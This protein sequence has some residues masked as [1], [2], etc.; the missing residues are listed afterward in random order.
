MATLPP[1][2]NKPEPMGERERRHAMREQR[3]NWEVYTQSELLHLLRI[4]LEDER[5]IVPD[6]V[7]KARKLPRLYK[8]EF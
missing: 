3:E 8:P 2:F 7:L 4:E 6:F 5:L 1:G